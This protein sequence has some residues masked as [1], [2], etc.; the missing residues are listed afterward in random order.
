MIKC[1]EDLIG[2]KVKIKSYEDYIQVKEICEQFGIKQ[3]DWQGCD[4][5]KEAGR[6]FSICVSNEEVEDA[7]LFLVTTE[8]NFEDGVDTA[9]EWENLKEIQLS[10]FAL[11]RNVPTKVKY[12]NIVTIPDNLR[13]LFGEGNLATCCEDGSYLAIKEDGNLLV[14]IMD[15]N[16]YQRIEEE[17]DWKEEVKS[18]IKNK[19]STIGKVTTPINRININYLVDHF[20]DKFLDL[21]RVALRGTGELK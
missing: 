1:K 15:N 17:V 9:V 8:E 2:T 21:C 20:P 11:E 13:D 3:A 7:F 16:I 6:T 5:S 19:V 10:E 12:V 4:Y 18:F 14:A